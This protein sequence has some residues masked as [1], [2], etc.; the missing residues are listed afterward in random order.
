VNKYRFSL[1]STDKYLNIPIEIKVDML[2]RDDLINEYEENV[3]EEIINPIED[4]EVTRFA[5]KDW[6]NDN[7]IGTSIEYQFY[8]FD[9]S[10]DVDSTN[11]LNE[12]LWVNDYV[13]TDNPNF[14][15]ECFSDSEIYYN[16][17]SFK[18]SFFK[19]DL[20]DS[21]NTETQQLYLSIVIPTQQG[22]TRLSNTS[23]P[24]SI[25]PANVNIKIPDFVLDFIGDKEGYFI[26]WLKNPSYLNIETFYMSAK[27]F[28]GKTG[29]FIRM[30]NTPQSNLSQKFTF[31]KSNKF[32]YKVELDGENY[33]YEIKDINTNNRVGT[34][35]PIKWYEY[36]NP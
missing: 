36:M 33:V 4:F 27:F 31:D 32:Y 23:S 6:D 5:H 12:T 9:R 35:T 18:K 25:A 29:Q 8:F 13:F 14:S 24:L 22:K 26:Y 11:S 10:V 34:T 20:Y 19:L 7:Q 15:G 30:M 17:N 2:G 3:I 16:A 28:N 21:L 1:G